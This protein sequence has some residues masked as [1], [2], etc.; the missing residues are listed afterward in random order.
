MKIFRVKFSVKIKL[1]VSSA[2]MLKITNNF[3]Y[4]IKLAN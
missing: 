2:R 3:Q 1:K 4:N